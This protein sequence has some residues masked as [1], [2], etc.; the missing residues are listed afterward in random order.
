MR[1]DVGA[2]RPEVLDSEDHQAFD[3]QRL[4][5]GVVFLDAGGEQQAFWMRES[6]VILCDIKM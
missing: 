2:A 1:L 6:L 3:M 5:L 4:V